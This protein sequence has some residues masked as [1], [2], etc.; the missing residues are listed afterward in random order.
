MTENA[1]D[2]DELTRI[3]KAATPGEWTTKRTEPLKDQQGW[4][5]WEPVAGTDK[6]CGVWR[7]RD[8][9]RHPAADAQFIAA[10]NPQTA[11]A[12]IAALKAVRAPG[13]GDRAFTAEDAE[14]LRACARVV[15][16][17]YRPFREKPMFEGVTLTAYV[18][19]V[20]DHIERLSGPAS[21]GG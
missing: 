12:L 15:D 14:A 20:A 1:L 11:L 10:F 8:G 7:R 6:P 4:A 18:R 17:V 19:A 16:S 5:V 21:G 13:L 2:L 3:A 9:G